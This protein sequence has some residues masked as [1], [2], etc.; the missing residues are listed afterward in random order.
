MDYLD[1]FEAQQNIIDTQEK[2][3]R[4]MTHLLMMHNLLDDIK[5]ERRE[6]HEQRN[7]ESYK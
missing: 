5:E 4:K 7:N 6:M 1:I 3:I 2:L